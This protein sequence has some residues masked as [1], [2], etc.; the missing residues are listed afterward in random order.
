MKKL[1]IFQLLYS[2]IFSVTSY[3]EIPNPSNDYKLEI[4]KKDFEFQYHYYN[5]FDELIRT[6][7]YR[8]DKNGLKGQKTA[9][10]NYKFH[11]VG[12]E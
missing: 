11:S 6:E 4:E 3:C 8:I 10:I 12:V 2:T 1:F 5:I 7:S 9:E